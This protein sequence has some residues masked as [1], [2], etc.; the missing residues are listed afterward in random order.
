LICSP[1]LAILWGSEGRARLVRAEAAKD[2]FLHKLVGAV[3][4][5]VIGGWCGSTLTRTVQQRLGVSL[6]NLNRGVSDNAPADPQSRSTHR[7]RRKHAGREDRQ[8]LEV[9]PRAVVAPRAG[10]QSH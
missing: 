9:R 5:G 4:P 7:C 6:G 1:F 3:V 8:L 10:R 2:E